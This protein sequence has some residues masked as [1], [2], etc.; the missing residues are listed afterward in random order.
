MQ[1]FFE[2]RTAS[3]SA[4]LDTDQPSVRHIQG[5]IRR[6]AAV[7]VELAGG[8]LLEGVIR[9]QDAHALAIHPGADQPLILVTRQAVVL[10]REKV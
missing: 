4:S 10:L 5:L 2:A 1:S 7:V 8:R 6:Q 9:W 3:R